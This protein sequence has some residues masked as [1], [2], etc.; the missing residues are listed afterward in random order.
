MHI[1]IYTQTLYKLIAIIPH[2][3]LLGGEHSRCIILAS[4]I[5]CCASGSRPNRESMANAP[6]Q[7][8]YSSEIRPT[9]MDLEWEGGAGG[10]ETGRLSL[11]IDTS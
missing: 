9:L 7:R 1:C 8:H 5:H 6:H 10:K 3:A 11:V 2:S 4:L